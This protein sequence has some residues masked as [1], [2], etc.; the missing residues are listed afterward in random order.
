MSRT[1]K[2]SVPTITTQDL[3]TTK[4]VVEELG[5]STETI[6]RAIRAGEL[7]AYQLGNGY[8]TT[9]VWLN[10]YLQKKLVTPTPVAV[11]G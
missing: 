5:V 4:Q 10:E 2:I 7:R 1:R 8:K 6:K 11:E 3:L 9:R